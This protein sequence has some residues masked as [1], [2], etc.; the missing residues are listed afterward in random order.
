ME[1]QYLLAF[2]YEY[3]LGVPQ[4]YDEARKWWLKAAAHGDA[5][6][7]ANLGALYFEGEGV[8]QDYVTSYAWANIAAAQGNE[9]AQRNRDLA[10]A[11]L[12]AASLGEAQKLSKDYFKR[13]VEPFQ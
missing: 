2:K 8:P 13:Y 10:A 4:D 1:A 6:A 11:K 9:T 7:Q 12:D 5:M 3:G